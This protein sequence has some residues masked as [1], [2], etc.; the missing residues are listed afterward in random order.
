M[1]TAPSPPAPLPA[2]TTPSPGEGRQAAKEN[3]LRR[4]RC[5]AV[6]ALVLTAAPLAAQDKSLHWAEVAVRAHL[7][8]EGTLHVAER[9]TMVF[10][11]DWNGGYRTFRLG[12]GQRL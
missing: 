4:L 7:D 9:Q 11:G 12:I 10:T 2:P 6:L 3:T 8:G 5:G 1:Q